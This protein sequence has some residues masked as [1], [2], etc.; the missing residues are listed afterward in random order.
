MVGRHARRGPDPRRRIPDRAHRRRRAPHHGRG[1]PRGP[2]RRGRPR[3][4][5]RPHAGV[6][7]SPPATASLDAVADPV[8]LLLLGS[9]LILLVAGVLPGR[10]GERRRA[11]LATALL[12]ACLTALPV[13]VVGADHAGG[14]LTGSPVW[15]I[16]AQ[17]LLVL[18]LV[19]W[20]GRR[21]PTRRPL[22][23]SAPRG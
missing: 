9:A 7:G 14:A 15:S 12:P 3:A 10:P 8:T 11:L 16:A 17:A 6:I 20:T 13:A 2:R 22:R 18:G 5:A 4:V 23:A 19:A 1:R 21:R